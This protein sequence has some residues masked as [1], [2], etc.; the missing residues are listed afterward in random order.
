MRYCKI[1]TIVND[2]PYTLYGQFDNLISYD[3][4]EYYISEAIDLNIEDD[5]EELD[6]EAMLMDDGGAEFKC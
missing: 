5:E 2:I 6:L 4:I 1:Q 3:E